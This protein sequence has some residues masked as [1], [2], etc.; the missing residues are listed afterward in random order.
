VIGIIYMKSHGQKAYQT[1]D[2]LISAKALE[3]ANNIHEIAQN[4]SNEE[5]I[6]I[7]V[8]KQLAFI[9]KQVG[10]EL[11]GKH[12]FT[13][14]SGRVDSVYDRVLIEYKNPKN[15]GSRIGLTL[16]STGSAKAVKQIKSRFYDLRTQFGQPMNSLFGVCLDG[17]RFIFVRYVND[18]WHIQDPI[19]VNRSSSERFLW[20][21]FNLG[22]K[23]K[24]FSPDS[25]AEDFGSDSRLT[26]VGIRSLYHTINSSKHPRVA[27]FFNQ[28]KILFGEVC[29]YNVYDP[30]PKIK[31]L[32]DFYEIGQNKVKTA[33]LLFAIHTYYALFMKLLASEIMAFFHNIPTP[34]E[35]MIRSDSTNK[36]KKEMEYLES[37][38]IFRH[39]NI[40]NFLEGDLFSWYTS[41]WSDSVSKTIHDM[42]MK[43]DDYNPGTF[44]E[45]PNNSRDLLKKLY[46]QLFPKKVRHDLGEYYTPDWLA[47]YVIDT[48]KFDGDPD[49]RLLDPAC[50]SGT[51]LVS[52]INRIRNSYVNNR[53]KYQFDEGEL[54]RKILSNVIGFDLNPLAVMA[55]RTNYLIAIRDLLGYVDKVEIPIYLCDSIMTPSEYGDLFIGQQGAVKEIRT[56]ATKFQ[57]PTEITEDREVV[58]RYADQLE[59]C[60]LNKYSSVEFI[61]RCTEENIPISNQKPHIELFN[62]LLKLDSENKNGIWARIIKNAFAPLFIKK[63]DFIIGNP[64]WINWES[65]PKDYRDSTIDLWDY[66]KLRSKVSPYVRLGNVKKELSALFV[67]VTAHRYLKNNG[68]LGFVITQSIFKSGANAG[69]RCFELPGNVPLKVDIISDMSLFL[70][71]EKAINRT[72]VIK[73]IKGK[74]TDYPVKYDV[75]VPKNNRKV[76]GEIDVRSI[77]KEFTILNWLAAPV[78]PSNQLSPWITVPKNIFS[79]MKLIL[80]NQN[81][82]LIKNSHAGSCTWLNG[83]YWV[84]LLK[85]GKKSSLIENMGDI[86]KR[87]IQKC[88]FSI[89]NDL[90]FPLL[91]GRDLKT[92]QAET[93][94]YIIVPHEKMGFSTPINIKSIKRKYPKA[95]QYFEKFRT[96]L[97]SRSGYKQLHNERDEYYV[98]GNLGQYT[99]KPYK[100]AFK[101][102]TEFFQCSVVF[103]KRISDDSSEQ[104]TIPDHTALFINCSS[105]DEAFYFSGLL[106]S[107]PVRL[108]L[109]CTS[110]GVQTQRY[111]TTDISRV[112]HLDYDSKNP[113]H[114][115]IVDISK[116]C[117]ELTAAG[118]KKIEKKEIE[119]AFACGQLWNLNKKEINEILDAFKFMA[120]LRKGK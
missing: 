42:V 102:L 25:L 117:H 10:I 12:E 64:P 77:K 101:D 5:E 76:I 7:A 115:N 31:L 14:A 26:Q 86:G 55:A 41:E 91:R 22:T 29:G 87:K 32:A 19:P 71:F 28:W 43:L 39:L 27:L 16:K 113:T 78:E 38:S 63:V 106:N 54:C 120:K 58:S 17:K 98:V 60:V 118:N 50:G 92:W 34:L 67:Y 94:L 96:P 69:F 45:N 70:P 114:T 56:A 65:L 72:A 21:L 75:W 90:L 47:E 4:A 105:K 20:A 103:P 9:Q 74:K 40:M 80:G 2:N 33:E 24:S 59:L 48:V 18:K 51:F 44:S 3:F 8:E 109:Y 119:L 73:I 108:A 49:K 53:E 13:V 81:E 37:G 100:V 23:G 93:E 99:I 84:R 1:L 57:I 95:Y 107:A 82:K 97:E 110:V 46:Q 79:Y 88:N 89:E 68:I 52:I 62:T 104:P 83:V 85:P 36:L 30:T 35:K 116:E 15:S 11:E 6:R 112:Q 111:F 61:E 66:Y